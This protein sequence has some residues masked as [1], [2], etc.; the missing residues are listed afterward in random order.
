MFF[1][2]WTL[3]TATGNSYNRS[4]GY[5]R[6]RIRKYEGKNIFFQQNNNVISPP[7]QM[8]FYNATVPLASTFYLYPAS[9]SLGPSSKTGNCPMESFRKL[10]IR[11]NLPEGFKQTINLAKL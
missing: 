7:L 10:L 8:H 1:Y 2:R 3:H 5:A 6:L 4:I 9:R 11:C